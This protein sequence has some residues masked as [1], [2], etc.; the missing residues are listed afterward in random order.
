MTSRFITI[1]TDWVCIFQ[2]SIWMQFQNSV[3]VSCVYLERS[4]TQSSFVISIYKDTD[5]REPHAHSGWCPSRMIVVWVTFIPAHQLTDFQG[6]R[7]PLKA[8]PLDYSAQPKLRDCQLVNADYN[9]GF[10]L[11][12]LLDIL[13]VSNPNIYVQRVYLSTILKDL[14]LQ[15]PPPSLNRKFWL[16]GKVSLL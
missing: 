10:Q 8:T 14:F 7:W 2:A 12:H 1:E 11:L 6:F 4:P 3:L 5:S 9:T 13:Q 15:V 16:K